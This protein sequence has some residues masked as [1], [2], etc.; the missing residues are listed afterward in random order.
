MTFSPEK[1]QNIKTQDSLTPVQKLNL[2]FKEGQESE[3]VKNILKSVL[4]TSF[5]EKLETTNGNASKNYIIDNLAEVY[6]NSQNTAL[7]FKLRKKEDPEGGSASL[8][9]WLRYSIQNAD[10]KN[11]ELEFVAHSLPSQKIEDN[12]NLDS[13]SLET[14]EFTKKHITEAIENLLAK[15]A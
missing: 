12:K 14:L 10:I 15:A 8:A 3:V 7:T 11:A 13:H 6:S 9:Y 1:S 4:E 2:I 5:T